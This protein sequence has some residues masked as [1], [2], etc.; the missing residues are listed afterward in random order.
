MENPLPLVP[1]AVEVTTSGPAYART[2]TGCNPAVMTK[3]TI[4]SSNLGPPSDPKSDEIM[5]E[6]FITCAS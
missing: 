4:Y 2:K 6:L 5:L 1:S 3:S